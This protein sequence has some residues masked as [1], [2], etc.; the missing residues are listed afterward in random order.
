[1][2]QGLQWRQRG[3]EGA[4]NGYVNHAAVGHHASDW[5]RRQLCSILQ[6]YNLQDSNC[7]GG[8][9]CC[10]TWNLIH[11]S[12]RSTFCSHRCALG[13][14]RCI[15]VLLL[16]CR[17]L[18]AQE[19]DLALVNSNKSTSRIWIEHKESLSLSDHSI[20]ATRTTRYN[21]QMQQKIY[22]DPTC[23]EG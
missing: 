21:N 13:S 10:R 22:K 7:S 19:T 12:W 2:S 16:S 8:K 11:F 20:H 14:S 1:M 3:R 4:Q 17:G 18:S 9:Q 6:S 5:K 23:C 15:A